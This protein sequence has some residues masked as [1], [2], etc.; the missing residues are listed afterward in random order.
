MS[1]LVYV[2]MYKCDPKEKKACDSGCSGGLMTNAYEYLIEAGGIEEESSY[3]Y[4]GKKGECKFKPE[5]VAVKV[6]NFTTIP[7]DENQIATYLV[8]HGPLAGIFNA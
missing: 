1:I 3:P 6:A 8:N 7:L 5:N 4:T 2:C